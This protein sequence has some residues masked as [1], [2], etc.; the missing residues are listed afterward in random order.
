MGT[1]TYKPTS[2][3]MRQKIGYTFEEL[4]T[5]RPLRSL[6]E[7]KSR[8]SGRNNEGHVTVR[9]RGCGHKRKYRVID[10]KRNKD[11]I[12]GTVKTI[13][14]DPNRTARI[15][16]IAYRDGERRYIIAPDGLRVGQTVHSGPT[17]D[18]LPGNT[19]PIRNIPAGTMIHN[20][21]LQPGKG[22]QLA[23]TAGAAAQ[24]VAKEGEMAQIKLPSGEIRLIRMECRAT[25]GQ[26]GNIEHENIVIGKAGRNRWLGRR[27]RVRAV[28]MNPVDHPMGGGEGKSSGGRHPCS[29]SGV[30]AKGFKTRRNKRT[31]RFILKRRPK[32]SH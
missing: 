2:P 23:R 3:S 31:S 16:L 22:G 9:F 25:I 14:Y 21:E 8:I 1:R 5:D 6:L 32:G 15:A 28:A 30:P 24:I 29:A 13:E 27:S 12:P 7:K 20:L 11:G 4:T 19:L 17:A 26:V 10:F 18:I